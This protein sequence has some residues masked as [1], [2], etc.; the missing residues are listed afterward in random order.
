MYA[1]VSGIIIAEMGYV[2]ERATEDEEYAYNCMF[3]VNQEMPMDVLPLTWEFLTTL[4]HFKALNPISFCDNATLT[5]AKLTNSTAL[6][7][8]E[9]ELVA[10]KPIIGAEITFLE[11]PT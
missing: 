7:T 2:L 8:K 5:A 10:K 9:K 4:A 3:A 11:I 6:F 1:C